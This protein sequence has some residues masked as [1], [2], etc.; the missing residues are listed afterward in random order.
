ML[1]KIV[2]GGGALDGFQKIFDQ[3][4][5]GRTIIKNFCTANSSIVLRTCGDCGL[6]YTRH[7]NVRNSKF[8]GPG[9]TIIGANLK[10]DDKVSFHNVSVYGY[11][12]E[13]TR[14]AYACIENSG[15]S[16]S[17]K[18]YAPGQPGNGPTC[19]YDASEVKVIN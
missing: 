11:N 4:G 17:F 7:V 1:F 6:Q 14:M 9:L 18:G 2:D 8:M 15:E 13:K 19:T 5:P 12:N 16:A 3:N 10:Y